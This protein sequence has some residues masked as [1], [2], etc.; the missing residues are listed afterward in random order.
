MA[1]ITGLESFPC[2][3]D[4]AYTLA[5]F[6]FLPSQVLYLVLVLTPP[7]V[8]LNGAGFNVAQCGKV[9]DAGS[10]QNLSLFFKRIEQ[11]TGYNLPM[12][13]KQNLDNLMRKVIK[14]SPEELTTEKHAK[15]PAKAQ[16]KGA[17]NV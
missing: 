12:S 15:R 11:G 5:L 16:D 10:F 17:R 8:R 1:P 3:D 6:E 4:T 14:V 13:G 9:Q 2:A 7:D